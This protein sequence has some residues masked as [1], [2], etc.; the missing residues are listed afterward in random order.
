[1]IKFILKKM[2]TLKICS[3]KVI[4]LIFE[5]EIDFKLHEIIILY[6]NQEKS[7]NS[8]DIRLINL[9]DLFKPRNKNNNEIMKH[10]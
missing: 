6:K 8:Y 10:S 5:V 7:N 3:Q 1:M 2:K 4:I 9:K